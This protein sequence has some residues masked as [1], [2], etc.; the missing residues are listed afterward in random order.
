MAA[1]KKAASKK[2][3]L[4]KRGSAALATYDYGE[5]A[6][7]GYEGTSQADFA[8]PFLTVLQSLSPEVTKGQASYMED[9]EAGMLMDTVSKMLFD[10]DDGIVIVPCLTSHVFTEWVPREEGGGGGGGFR[11]VHET[12]SEI[13]KRCQSEAKDGFGKLPTG[14]GTEL[15]ETFYIFAIVLDSVDATEASGFFM[16]PFTS[17]KISVYRKFMQR[18][19]QVKGNPP[20]FA[21]RVLITSVP[22]SN[23][24]GNFYNFKLT[25]A[26]DDEL[27]ASLI[28]PV[29]GKTP[30]K[31]IAAAKQ[32][33][34]QIAKGAVRGAY[35]SVE[36]SGE[37]DAS[38]DG[39]F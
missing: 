25:A 16:I 22:D 19:R 18:L 30:S 32:F 13:V 37:G 35:E 28:P 36:G 9:A 8:I 21:N 31:I 29:D 23:K 33:K 38:G 20:L 12:D 2:K 15:V 34:E 5:D 10:G 6:G 4:A 1:K 17:T 26:V 14:D 27:V 3:A 24:K 39:V 7:K 11:G